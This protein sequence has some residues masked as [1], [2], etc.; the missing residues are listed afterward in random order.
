M[1]GKLLVLEGKPTA[2]CRLLPG[3]PPMQPER[4]PGRVYVSVSITG[5]PK[6]KIEPKNQRVSLGDMVTF[7]C[8]AEGEPEPQI[9]WRKVNVV[10]ETADRVTILPNNS[11]RSVYR[12]INLQPLHLVV[13][14]RQ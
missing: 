10:L 3:L 14:K 11:L 4:K 9:E 2:I 1:E 13:C 6:F 7:D 5:P 8:M 12:N